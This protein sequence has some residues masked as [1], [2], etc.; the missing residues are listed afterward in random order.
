MLLN[1]IN[2]LAIVCLL[3][4]GCGGSD[5]GPAKT[6]GWSHLQSI[7]L[8]A[9]DAVVVI[10]N[11][12][13][14]D[15]SGGE[16]SGAVTYT[17]S[18]TSIAEVSSTGVV[19]G[20][21]LGSVTITATKAADGSYAEAT[22]SVTI[23]VDPLQ[24]QTIAF[25]SAT[26]SL[27]IGTDFLLTATGGEGSGAITYTSSDEAVATVSAEG[28]VTAI[29]LGSTEITAVKAADTEYLEATA[30]TTVTVEAE[31][32]VLDPT[33]ITG[34]PSGKGRATVS[35]D[36]VEGASTYNL[37]RAK[38]SIDSITNYASLNDGTLELNVVSPLTLTDLDNGDLYYFRVTASEGA[39]ESDPSNEVSVV[40]RDPLN[41][42]GIL[43][44]GNGTSGINT[45]CTEAIAGA[46]Q[47]C[48]SGRDADT[49]LSK[50]GTGP[51]GFDFTKLGANG[52]A[53][54]VQTAAW[55]DGGDE[56]AGTIWSCVRDNVTGLVWE[57][58]TND[59]SPH[60][61]DEK[62]TWANR[63]NLAGT[64]NTEALCGIDDW[65]VPSIMELATIVNNNKQDPT[66]DI[67]R[68]PNGKSQAYWSSNPDVND[69]TK[70]WTI[71][72]YS[73]INNLKTKVSTFQVR[74]VSGTYLANGTPDSRYSI[75][76][77]GTATDLITGLMWRQ[78]PEGLSGTDCS[79]G[80]AGTKVWG[81]TM[82][83]AKT[84][85]FAGYDDWRLPNIK[86]LMTIVDFDSA[87]TTTNQ[88]TFPGVTMTVWT[89][90]PVI[91]G[92]ASHSWMLHFGT[93]LITSKSRVNSKHARLQVR[94]AD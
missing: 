77:D 67:T 54:A 4:A 33:T 9:G 47:D 84:S 80:A 70:A 38:E 85:T 45:T 5:S 27:A 58:K 60:S 25:A 3:L 36:A 1:K 68:F 74:L 56:A 22:A 86:E 26:N 57:T 31:P 88:A 29:A 63:D 16:G 66:F 41:D 14:T 39:V 72:F 94:N 92:D 64:T 32:I 11:T 93:G 69:G 53:L 49:T 82:K 7:S 75:N 44:S 8:S 87:G 83:D 2:I 90:S 24:D 15:L 71:N 10:G 46:E 81:G 40:T 76:G 20:K 79:T 62:V 48:A 61:V 19:T 50:I 59:T 52:E 73:G 43:K 89:S 78:C 12:L 21:Q 37:Y 23:T 42:S 30:T 17:S 65:R 91:G 28:L 51:A 13:P 55:D 18:D 34:V 6:E 35:W